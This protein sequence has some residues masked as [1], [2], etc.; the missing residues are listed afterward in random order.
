MINQHRELRQ[1]GSNGGDDT[2][3]LITNVPFFTRVDPETLTNS[4]LRIPSVAAVSSVGATPWSS[5]ISVATFQRGVAEAEAAYVAYENV[6]AY[7]FFDTLGMTLAAGRSFERDRGDDTAGDSSQPRNIVVDR[8]FA[9]QLSFGSPNDAIDAVIYVRSAD[10]EQPLGPARIIGVVE[11][12]PLH[13]VGL[14]ASSNVYFL[15][16]YQFYTIVRIRGDD[17]RHSRA[18]IEA[19]WNAHAPNIAIPFRF[20]DELFQQNYV[21]F[22]RVSGLL[23]GLALFALLISA[24]SLLSI[25]TH[26]TA[27]RSREVAVRK[28]FGASTWSVVAMFVRSYTKPVLIAN[29]IAWP[30]GAIIGSAYLE[31]FLL[32]T[33]LGLQ[34]FIAGL[35]LTVVIAVGTVATQVWR[36][37]SRSPSAAL[38]YD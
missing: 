28:T 30:L 19:A 16:S 36:A 2:L 35:A 8:A 4:L 22:E 26:D 27:H 34:P 17:L 10:V 5:N 15:D 9:E 18:A 29:A 21:V 38:R 3:A 31:I 20:M 7:D 37:A 25:A 13:L 14:G 1:S 24:A 33:P 32:R 11:N 23:H 12:R 6:V